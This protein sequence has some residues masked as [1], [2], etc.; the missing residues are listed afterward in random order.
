MAEPQPNVSKFPGPRTGSG[1]NT[2]GTAALG[3]RIASLEA[4]LQH[5][6]TREDIEK[7]ARNTMK[8]VVGIMI[9][10]LIAAVA[11]TAAVMGAV[12]N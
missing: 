2:S 6:A 8:W 7:S 5:L 4:H 10:S 3:E 9:T 1:D 11:A 12:V